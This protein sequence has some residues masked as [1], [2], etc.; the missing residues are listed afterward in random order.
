VGNYLYAAF[1]TEKG[2]N[3]AVPMEIDGSSA[4]TRL[5]DEIKEMAAALAS[6]E[7]LARAAAANQKPNKAGRPTLFP[8][9]CIQGLARVYHNN[10]GSKPGRGNGPFANFASAFFIAAGQRRI[11]RKSLIDAI[12]DAHRQFKP[13]WFDGKPPHS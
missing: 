5:V 12:Q 3:S 1:Y 7:R 10:T 8:K 13:S 9:D 2:I 6:L 4:L 11:N